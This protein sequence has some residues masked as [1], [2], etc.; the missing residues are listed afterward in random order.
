MKKVYMVNVPRI[1]SLYM[2]LALSAESA[3][4]CVKNMRWSDDPPYTYITSDKPDV[5][6]GISVDITRQVLSQLGCELNLIEMPWA[7][8]LQSLKT[9]YI[10]ILSGAYNTEERKEFAYFSK[11]ALYSPNILF[12]RKEDTNLWQF[13]SLEDIIN[14]SFNL[15]VQINVSYSQHYDTLKTQDN[16][17]RHLTTNSSRESLWKMLSLNRIDGVIADK[18]TG[19]QELKKLGFINSIIPS[20]LIVSNDASYF[21]FSKKTIDLKFISLFDE[22]LNNLIDDGTLNRIENFHINR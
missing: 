8:A 10:D 11:Q 4:S 9:G 12:I 2:L 15:G 19:N 14:T 22:A 7:R 21:A 16:F 18:A 13:T 6:Q 3:L 1:L 5:I 17:A 20:Q